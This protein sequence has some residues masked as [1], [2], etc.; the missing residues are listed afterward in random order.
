MVDFNLFIKYFAGK[1]DPEEALLVE[2]WATASEE[3][4]AIFRDLHQSWLIAGDELYTMPDIQQEWEDLM[5]KCDVNRVKV[6]E[7]TKKHWLPRVAAVAA[8]FVTAI[9]GFYLFNTKNQNEPTTIAEATDQAIQLRLGDGTRVTVQPD[10]ELVYPVTFKH[11]IRE[12]TLVGNGSFDV[13]HNPAQPFIVHLGDLHVKV[14]GTAFDIER[15]RTWISVKVNRGKVA[16]YNKKDTIIITE[17]A[18][19][20]YIK[21]DKKLVLEQPLPLTGNFNFNNTPL[22][23][24]FAALSAHFKVQINIANPEINNCLLSAGFEAQSL[25][26]ILTAISATFNLHANIEHQKIQISGN[27]CK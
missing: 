7:P 21:S 4:Q 17:G 10:G 13:V 2:D 15:N 26:D 11:N 8:I 1:A 16:F 6:F 12:V 3:Q 27:G 14:L 9:A 22:K 5:T 18:I 25:K 19:G 23:D 24:V 20:K